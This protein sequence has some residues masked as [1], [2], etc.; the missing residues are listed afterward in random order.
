MEICMA[1]KRRRGCLMRVSV[2]QQNNFTPGLVRRLSLFGLAWLLM[3]EANLPGTSRWPSE[4]QSAALF[5]GRV[6]SVELVRVRM[7]NLEKRGRWTAVVFDEL[8]KAEVKIE[9]VLKQESPLGKT[10]TVYYGHR[11]DG[12]RPDSPDL[13][14]GFGGGCPG[15]PKISKGQRARF[16]CVI[17]EEGTNRV[18]F[19]PEGG[20][21]VDVARVDR[22]SQR[23]GR[24]VASREML[25]DSPRV[26]RK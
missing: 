15:Y 19:I 18:L 5:V 4:R 11:Y 6:K 24:Y 10:A 17:S 1:T 23:R 9:S 25:A 8:W 22:S 14:F 26:A 3:C 12:P 7:E 2:R 21:V 13:L 20:W 16:Y